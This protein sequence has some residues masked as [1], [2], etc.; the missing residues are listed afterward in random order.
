MHR[1]GA[2]EEM[3]GTMKVHLG[4]IIIYTGDCLSG[5]NCPLLTAND[6]VK[7]LKRAR[8]H[9]CRKLGSIN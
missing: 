3:Y 1:P 9:N 7:E 4:H 8:S 6:D 2:V 5:D